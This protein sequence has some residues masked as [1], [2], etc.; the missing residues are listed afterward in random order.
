MIRL[1]KKLLFAIEVVLDIAYN[2]AGWCVRPR[3]PSVK[4]YRAATSS[5]CCRNWSIKILLGIRGPAAAIVWRAARGSPGDIVRTVRG[6]ETAGGSD[7]RPRRS[8]L[9]H[10]RAALWVELQEETMRR[11]D[12]LTWS[13]AAAHTAPVSPVEPPNAVTEI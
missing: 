6:P 4:G 8:A 11:L 2:G 10:R 13:C 5:R 9:G 1:S 3:L 12:A 7:Q